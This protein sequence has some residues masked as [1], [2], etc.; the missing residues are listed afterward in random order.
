[1]SSPGQTGP[2]EEDVIRFPAQQPYQPW[3]HGLAQS[4]AR[5]ADEAMP[6][7]PGKPDPPAFPEPLPSKI[8]TSDLTASQ[9][10]R[11]SQRLDDYLR[12]WREAEPSDALRTKK[13]R[14]NYAKRALTL[15]HRYLDIVEEFD[16]RRA[17]RRK[18]AEGRPAGPNEVLFGALVP[19]DRILINLHGVGEP[20]PCT[21]KHRSTEGH[22]V[23]GL[24]T[25]ADY[26]YEDRYEPVRRADATQIYDRRD[27]SNW[28]E[29]FEEEYGLLVRW[30]KRLPQDAD[31]RGGV[32]ARAARLRGLITSHTKFSGT[33]AALPASE[34]GAKGAGRDSTGIPL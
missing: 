24:D 25:T 1:M 23:V 20:V 26:R 34:A 3:G 28:L 31:G 6:Q 17:Q 12:R 13:A 7:P 16:E 14:D 9:L 22:A 8:K 15:V 33:L 32:H 2:E 21:V 29:N 11:A 5:A 30:L 27:D 19:G 18:I 4:M 10:V